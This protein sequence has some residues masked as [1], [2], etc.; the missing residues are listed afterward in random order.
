MNA[1]RLHRRRDFSNEFA[2]SSLKMAVDIL[3][4]RGPQ[5][6]SECQLNE[7]HRQPVAAEQP[8]LLTIRARSGQWGDT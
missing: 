3:M 2:A 5:E 7:Q 1:R 8:E 6:I 4:A